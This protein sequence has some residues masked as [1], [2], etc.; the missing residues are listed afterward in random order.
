MP[1]RRVRHKDRRPD[2]E[3][4]SKSQEYELTHGRPLLPRSPG[5]SFGGDIEFFRDAWELHGPRIM[6]EWDPTKSCCFRPFAWWALE[7]GEERPVNRHV[8]PA[9]LAK[10]RPGHTY[11]G[12]FSSHICGFPGWLQEP[13]PNYLRRLGLL[14]EKETAWLEGVEL[15]EDWEQ[16]CLTQSSRD[17]LRKFE[18]ERLLKN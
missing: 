17:V 15:I 3:I 18:R 11:Y 16:S 12:Y 4:I 7:Y 13:E 14:T 5:E 2:A 6:Y 8:T 9:E 10:W 1:R